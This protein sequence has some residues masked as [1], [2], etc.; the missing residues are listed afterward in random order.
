MYPRRRFLRDLGLASGASFLGPLVDPWMRTAWG[1]SASAQRL[2]I[3]QTSLGTRDQYVPAPD[4]ASALGF[5]L[6][7]FRA[8]EDVKADV[9]VVRNLYNPFNQHLHGNRWALTSAPGTGEDEESPGTAT[10]DRFMAERVG[11]AAPVRSLNLALWDNRRLTTQSASGAGQP[12]PVDR[13]AASAFA[14]LFPDEGGTGG[15]DPSAARN[16]RTA[17]RRRLLDAVRGD[18]RRLERRLAGPEKLKL[19]TYLGSIDAIDGRLQ[20]LAETPATAS[21]SAV[22]GPDPETLGGARD[23]RREHADAM[24][25]LAALSLTCG[26]TQVVHLNNRP[27]GVDWL[28]TDNDEQTGSH[29]MWHGDG[30]DLKHDAWFS[31]QGQHLRTLWRRLQD[32]PEGAGSM[33]DNTLILWINSS[34]GGHHNGFYDYWVLTLGTLGGRLR[35]GFVDLPRSSVD[36]AGSDPRYTLAKENRRPST[37][38][39]RDYS[40]RSTADYFTTLNEAFGL[41]GETFGDARIR[42]GPIQE[43][44]T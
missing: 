20:A 43:M 21:C 3:Y 35:P 17:Q 23:P 22:E 18:V 24:V 28:P 38:S 8:L 30:T 11:S 40:V 2:V 16:R 25:E 32:T 10:F 1:Q 34:G 37:R 15:E 33:A 27:T 5:D 12:F 9:Q 36:N 31:L 4:P 41:P 39:N 29:S 26:L 7:S 13:E 42:Q 6:K 14:R 44:L 19:E